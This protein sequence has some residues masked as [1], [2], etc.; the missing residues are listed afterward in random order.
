MGTSAKKKEQ[1]LKKKVQ[2]QQFET[3]KMIEELKANREK[4]Q[5]L[6]V[7]FDK[8]LAERDKQLSGLRTH[9][10]SDLQKIQSQIQSSDIESIR[11]QVNELDVKQK[12]DKKDLL[13][14]K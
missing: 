4:I 9:L 11:K 3:E 7:Q 5:K 13:E 10:F 14:L 8:E 6:A 12:I 1:D 2:E